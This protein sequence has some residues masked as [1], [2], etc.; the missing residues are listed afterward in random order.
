MTLL[1]S[2]EARSLVVLLSFSHLDDIYVLKRYHLELL[3]VQGLHHGPARRRNLLVLEIG[4][5]SWL[6]PYDLK[7]QANILPNLDSK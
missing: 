1:V 2:N 3:N 5:S 6:I 7:F 4:P